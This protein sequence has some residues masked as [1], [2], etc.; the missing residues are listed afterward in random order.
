MV[1]DHL[2]EVRIDIAYG[3]SPGFTSPFSTETVS[4]LANSRPELR[5]RLRQFRQHQGN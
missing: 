3:P 5:E 2:G 4:I 1:W